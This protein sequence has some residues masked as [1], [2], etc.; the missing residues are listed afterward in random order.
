[1]FKKFLVILSS[2]LIVA[3]L[4]ACGNNAEVE[5]LKKQVAELKQQNKK[6][7]GDLN[8][9]NLSME[10]T[11]R[12]KSDSDEDDKVN[13]STKKTIDNDDASNKMTDEEMVMVAL[14]VEGSDFTD[15][16]FKRIMEELKEIG[17]TEFSKN[18]ALDYWKSRNAE[19]NSSEAY[20]GIGELYCNYDQYYDP[21]KAVKCFEKAI[22]IST[23]GGINQVPNDKAMYNLGLIYAS[24]EYGMK[25]LE[26]AKKYFTDASKL[27]NNYEAMGKLVDVNIEDGDF[28]S[29]AEN[30]K[31]LYNWTNE[32]GQTFYAYD[33]LSLLARLYDDGSL[34]KCSTFPLYIAGRNKQIMDYE[35]AYMCYEK[36]IDYYI[37]HELRT[38]E[39]KYED[40]VQALYRLGKMNENGQGVDVDLAKARAY[41]EEAS[42]QSKNSPWVSNADL[43]DEIESSLAALKYY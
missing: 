29:A 17:E 26:L 28:K 41:Y 32:I 19:W 21:K 36:S 15:E 13:N 1:M 24:D 35:T 23:S 42:A 12:R 39:Y 20:N 4:F 34:D 9:S 5:E 38:A 22:K 40:Y 6:I 16:H 2:I 43:I 7:N 3:G 31:A 10:D 14:W 37:Q 8:S 30:A 33:A 18:L 11:Q 27:G 25:D